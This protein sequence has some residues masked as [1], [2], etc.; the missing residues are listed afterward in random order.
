MGNIS[1]NQPKCDQYDQLILQTHKKTDQLFSPKET[2]NLKLKIKDARNYFF[3]KFN[4]FFY[5]NTTL[6]NHKVHPL[7]DN[8]SKMILSFCSN[9]QKRHNKFKVLVAFDDNFERIFGSRL[10]FDPLFTIIFEKMEVNILLFFDMTNL[11]TLYIKDFFDQLYDSVA[12]FKIA[13]KFDCMYFL[14]PSTEYLIK[15]ESGIFFIT[16]KTVP[17]NLLTNDEEI[18]IKNE[19]S[20]QIFVNNDK[21]KLLHALYPKTLANSYFEKFVSMLYPIEIIKS[22]I[23][24]KLTSEIESFVIVNEEPLKQ[25]EIITEKSKVNSITI[26][27]P[28]EIVFK[29]DKGVQLLIKKTLNLFDKSS[30]EKSVLIMKFVYK[31][32]NK[33]NTIN[34]HNYGMNLEEIKQMCIKQIK[35]LNTDPIHR[36]RKLI[37]DLLIF[38]RIS[39]ENQNKS[40]NGEDIMMR[41]ERQFFY[42]YSDVNSIPDN[43]LDKYQLLY[44]T[45][46]NENLKKLQNKKILNTIGLC[47][48]EL[49]GENNHIKFKTKSFKEIDSIRCIEEKDII[50]C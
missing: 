9:K 11:D 29:N 49:S 24:F 2:M 19:Y 10:D 3:T 22:F 17:N 15:N 8:F 18:I 28:P 47:L 39:D 50:H 36:Q 1:S 43:N 38:T 46:S 27:V 20:E 31:S 5:F 21:D 12:F 45:N 6:Y 41:R 37:I 40:S 35:N 34:E 4:Y 14:L 16:N 32:G 33:R 30:F 7:Y 26:E 42:W 44:I 25:I 23:N 13:K 48:Y